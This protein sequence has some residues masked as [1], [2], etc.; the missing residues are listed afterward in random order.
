MCAPLSTSGSVPLSMRDVRSFCAGSVLHGAV[1]MMKSLITTTLGFA[2]VA[3]LATGCGKK[4]EPKSVSTTSTQTTKQ[5]D[6]G[7]ATSTDVT[8]K[9][10]EMPDGSTSVESTQKTNTTLPAGTTK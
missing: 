2:V 8:T 9:T 4:P 1:W 3:T 10:T 7:E 5:E 6:T